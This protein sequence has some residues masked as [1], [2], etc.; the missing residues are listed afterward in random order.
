MPFS[1][2]VP[3]PAGLRTVSALEALATGKSGVPPLVLFMQEPTEKGFFLM[4]TDGLVVRAQRLDLFWS[5][6]TLDQSFSTSGPP[7]ESRPLS[8]W[9]EDDREEPVQ[10]LA[11]APLKLQRT[12]PGGHWAL[13]PLQDSAREE[14]ALSSILKAHLRVAPAAFRSWFSMMSPTAMASFSGS[15]P[16]GLEPPV[17]FIPEAQPD[18]QGKPSWAKYWAFHAQTM[19]P[20]GVVMGVKCRA[21]TERYAPKK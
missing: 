5:L 9:I 21:P 2:H 16:P 12:G 6:E 4:A 19:E 7:T 8:A 3:H 14:A 17:L 10:D 15:F 1:L 20:L 13:V 11:A 18:P